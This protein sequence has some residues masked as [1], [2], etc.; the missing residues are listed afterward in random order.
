M[1]PLLLTLAGVQEIQISVKV[2]VLVVFHYRLPAFNVE[3]S[4]Y[5]YIN[6]WFLV[7]LRE[8]RAAV[9]KQVLAWCC[10]YAELTSIQI[11]L[12]KS[13]FTE[14]LSPQE[15]HPGRLC[16]S[17]RPRAHFPCPSSGNWIMLIY[18]GGDEYDNHCGMEQR[19]AVVMISCSRH[20]LAVRH[21]GATSLESRW[22]GWPEV[23][24]NFRRGQE[25]SGWIRED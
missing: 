5:S 24:E 20:T 10:R 2:W 15:L 16:V 1:E 13:N 17:P 12:T 22:E 4:D 25:T 9:K 21:P 8:H 19:R 6:L 7:V 18:K 14:H 23:G 11:I 3:N